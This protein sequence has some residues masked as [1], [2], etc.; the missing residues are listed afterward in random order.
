MSEETGRRGE[1]VE[2]LLYTSRIYT[3]SSPLLDFIIY[4]VTTRESIIGMFD[5]II[6]MTPLRVDGGSNTHGI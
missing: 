3:T 2:E 5:A 1:C 4:F 6:K